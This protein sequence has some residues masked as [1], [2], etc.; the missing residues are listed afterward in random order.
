MPSRDRCLH[1][2][3]RRSA[4]KQ[5]TEKKFARSTLVLMRNDYLRN[6]ADDSL[7]QN[8]ISRTVIRSIVNLQ[9][10]VVKAHSPLTRFQIYLDMTPGVVIYQLPLLFY[11]HCLLTSCQLSLLAVTRVLLAWHARR[12]D[13][14]A[15]TLQSELA[16]RARS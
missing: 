13:L 10:L 12:L 3:G 11:P 16:R 15:S 5:Q 2:T 1:R 7:T 9:P 8:E 14:K 6:S 4:F